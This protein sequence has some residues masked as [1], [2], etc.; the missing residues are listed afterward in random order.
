MIVYPC[1]C[2][3]SMVCEV[4]RLPNYLALSFSLFKAIEEKINQLISTQFLLS[5]LFHFFYPTE[6][7][8]FINIFN[9]QVFFFTSS[10]KIL[11]IIHWLMLQ[12]SIENNSWPGICKSTS[13][14]ISGSWWM[15][16]ANG[17]ALHLVGGNRFNGPTWWKS[18]AELEV[19]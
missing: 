18:S 19:G 3:W 13:E 9:M 17:V 15:Q 4:N 6:P 16:L 7:V 2:V 5:F 12:S 11:A 1:T 8:S 14:K 10:W